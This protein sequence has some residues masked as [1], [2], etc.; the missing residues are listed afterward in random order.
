MGLIA[1]VKRWRYVY[2]W[3]LRYW[4]L[5]TA[6]GLHARL[7]LSVIAGI[8]G[9]IWAVVLIVTPS[10]PSRANQPHH[11]IIWFVV[12]LI[13][14]LLV[15]VAAYMM[16]GHPKAPNAQQSDMP[17]TDDGQSVKH[18]FGTGWVDDSFLLAWKLVGRS[19]IK[20][21]GGK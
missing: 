4:W 9:V 7:A 3:R 12:W 15:A 16:M 19:P 13:V 14:A 6:S 17:T 8:A 11:A 2:G 20:S 10:A 18:L 5:D 21:K 1:T